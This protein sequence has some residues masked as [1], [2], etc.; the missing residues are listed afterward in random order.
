MIGGILV[1][2]CSSPMRNT[3]PAPI[4]GPGGSTA[5]RTYPPVADAQ[6]SPQS[7]SRSETRIAA[8]QPPAQPKMSAPKPGNAVLVLMRRAED[9]KAK[10]DFSA[11]A[12]S[13]ERALRIEPAS[14]PLWHELADVRMEQG[15]PQLAMQLAAKSN[16]LTNQADLQVN[17][18]LLIARAKRA[19][20]DTAGAKSAMQQ[21]NRLKR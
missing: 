4:E 2:S 15:K 13:L 17:N 10:G 16:A 9:Q 21:A 14:A 6:T 3:S 18:W 12:I 19:V 20:G 7:D 11:A 1:T 8:Y 5:Q